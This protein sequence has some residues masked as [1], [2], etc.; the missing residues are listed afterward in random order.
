MEYI[1]LQNMSAPNIF[2]AALSDQKKKKM[3]K[4]VMADTFVMSHIP[5]L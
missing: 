1:Q 5:Y 2:Y 4:E 3:A